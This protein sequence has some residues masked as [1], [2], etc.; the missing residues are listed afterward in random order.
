[1]LD[2]RVIREKPDEVIAGLGKKGRD[3]KDEIARILELDEARRE[4]IASVEAMKAEQ[5]RASK[6]IPRLKK[7]G[8]D[9]TELMA[10]MKRLSGEIK[11]GDEKL[12][13]VETEQRDLLLGLPN[14]PD[15]DLLPGEKENNEVISVYHEVPAFSFEPKN[16]VDL[17]TDLGLIDY[18]RGA[19]LGG[20]GFWI[21]R[22]LGARLEW[23]LLNYF[24]DTHIG[25]G[26]EFMLVPH[27]LGYE[28][29]LTA[30]Q[31]PKFDDDVFW[32]ESE[33]G[34]KQ[35]LL[36][37]AETALVSMHRNEILDDADLP[38]KYIAYSPCYRREAGSYRADE[39]GMIRGHQFN[40]VEMVQYTR[41]EDSDKAF[42]ELVAKAEELMKGLNLHFRTVKL[43]AGDCSAAMAR[44]YDIEVYIPSMGGYK[45]V[46]SA[47][48]ARDYQAR[49][50]Q[51]R[52]RRAETGK[53]ELVHTL[54][55][56]GL[57]TSR[58]LPAILEQYQTE[59]G[60]V[61]VPEVLIPYIGINEMKK[62]TDPLAEI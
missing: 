49:R 11:E 41:P 17:A 10:R 1:M 35:F 18:P 2:I 30:G 52:F 55:A 33:S 8:A 58:L 24:I 44:T 26:Y 4:L 36:P 9:T 29:G 59:S 50:G 27:L 51:M 16:H 15:P 28:S 34:R 14:L 22:G 21:Y 39:R 13:A 19:K 32:L 54:N 60:S 5:N 57:A 45:E 7:E 40:K 42:G 6:D 37:T 31:F 3:A 48:N 43:A 46:S 38:L 56:S 25:D 47:S 61:R 62:K 12:S 23:A 20:N 53:P